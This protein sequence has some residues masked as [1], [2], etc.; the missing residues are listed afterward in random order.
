M[1]F[2]KDNSKCYRTLKTWN[3]QIRVSSWCISHW[4]KGNCEK[5]MQDESLVIK[6]SGLK[7]F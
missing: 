1:S 5:E 2:I 3:N 4:L 7:M 6:K